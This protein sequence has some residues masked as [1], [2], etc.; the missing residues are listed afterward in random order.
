MTTQ[1]IS[2]MLKAIRTY[3]YINRDC[4]GFFLLH[5]LQLF[6]LKNYSDYLNFIFTKCDFYG[7]IAQGV[8]SDFSG[9]KYLHKIVGKTEVPTGFCNSIAFNIPFLNL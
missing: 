2:R 3:F 6:L 8:I 1:N 9:N 5:F 4:L 7:Q